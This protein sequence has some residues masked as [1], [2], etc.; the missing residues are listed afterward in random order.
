MDKI[1]DKILWDDYFLTL[2]FVAAQRSIDIS[3]KCGCVI[4]SKDHR[5]LSIGYNGPL[6]GIKDETVPRGRPNKYWWT[7][8]SEE[9]ALLAYNGSNLDIEGAT[10]YITGLP[11][12][13]C[14]TS[15]L[16][17]GITRIVVSNINVAVMC[18]AGKNPAWDDC[19]EMMEQKNATLEVKNVLCVSDVLT[20]THSYIANYIED[21]RIVIPTGKIV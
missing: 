5:V 21:N 15:L 18:E 2:A 19:L 1:S 16:Q 7:I 14:L 3:T 10:A 4:V 17:K 9:N 13:R 11:C 12:D 20:K 8:H 6:K